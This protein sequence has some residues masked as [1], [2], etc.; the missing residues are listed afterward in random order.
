[1]CVFISACVCR[2]EKKTSSSLPQIKSNNKKKKE[3]HGDKFCLKIN[4]PQARTKIKESNRIP[5]R[6]K[7]KR[8][9]KKS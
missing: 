3:N 1:M 8:R 4:E 6:V 9:K 7:I 5:N 2:N